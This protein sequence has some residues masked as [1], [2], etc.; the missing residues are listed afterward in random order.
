MS[1]AKQ[2]IK[3]L[4]EESKKRKE[5]VY[6]VGGY[7][8]DKLASSKIEPRDVDFIYDGNIDS[9]LER[10]KES[11]Y[12]FF[13]IKR[14][15]NIYRCIFKDTIIDISKMKG[16]NIIEDLN[17]RDF[18][19]NAICIKLGENKIIDPFEGRK[20]LKNRIIRVVN[21]DSLK[22]D[23]VRI[24]RAIRLYISFGMHFNVDTENMIIKYAYKLKDVPGERV[25]SELMSIIEND[26]EGI[27]FEI[28]D[29][30]SILKFLIPYVEELKTIGKCKYHIEDVFTHI[31]LTYRI[32]KDILNNRIKV[33]N[34]NFKIFDYKIGG[35]SLRE[36]TAFSCFL[37]DIGKYEA[38]K[39]KDNKISF[40]EHEKRGAD[41]C[42]KL[43]ISYRVPKKVLE[44]IEAIVKEHMY[45]LIL[46]KNG[47][48]NNKR[49]EFYNFFYRCGKLSQ[50]IIIVSFCD[51]YATRILLD[52]ENE[53]E[54]YKV[55]IERMLYEY[56]VYLDVKREKFIDGNY[57]MDVL[58]I[59]G[60]AVGSIIDNIDK[61]R[62]LK[63]INTREE[64]INYIKKIKALNI[65]N[66]NY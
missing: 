24:L 46:F 39:K 30:F 51:N 53:K 8:R 37:H 31:N 42:R 7:I 43:C 48:K 49:E 40:R 45:P 34:L 25:F 9:L 17:M 61:L 32:F 47:F 54:Y 20:A 19:V 3:Y 16:N 63:E 1:Y 64:V 13:Q 23:P 15:K 52:R 36:Y 50:Y 6:L 44:F 4:S 5:N 58:G 38:Y 56:S 28:L 10:L 33:K 18:T 2:F 57:I 41:I 14:E 11:G 59:K 55:F 65:D 22:S 26:K 21:R 35:F 66:S 62:Y 60:E 29:T 12:K 27:A